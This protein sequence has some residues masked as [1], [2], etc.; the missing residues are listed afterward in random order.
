MSMFFTRRRALAR[1][2]S[3]LAASPLLQAQRAPKLIGEP[4][5]RIAPR[6]ELINVL[7]FAPMAE[8]KLDSPAYAAIAGGDRRFFDRITFRQRLMVNTLELD[9]TTELCGTTMFA[10]IL[11]GPASHQQRYHPEGERAMARGATAAKAVM[12]V[13]AR[14]SL[15][16]QEIAAEAQGPFWFQIHPEPDA[17]A[18]LNS[19]QAAVKAGCK[20]VCITVGAPYELSRTAGARGIAQAT[21]LG[22][23]AI[24]WDYVD[25]L[26]QKITVPILLKG[27]MSAEEAQVALE[28]GI[29]GIV[30]SNHGG[31]FI[32]GVADPM[33][34]LPGIAEAV[35]AKLPILIDGGFRRGSDVL[36]ALALGARAAFVARPAL[37]GLAAYG[38]EGVQSVLELLQTELASDM[39]MIGAVNPKAIARDMVK[40]HRR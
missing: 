4:A 27:I 33:K 18:V 30:V 26:R 34:V 7:E 10:P 16:I 28:K 14:S 35:G 11:V 37:W 1:F 36:K 25:R 17:M 40:I 23:P 29:Q 20:A 3:L 21:P 19:A 8:R 15:P 13:P 5:G 9:L 2:G 39:A 22:N 24:N 12:V 31:R 32:T 38:P 6:A